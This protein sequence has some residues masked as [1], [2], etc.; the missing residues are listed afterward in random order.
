[1]MEEVSPGL[2]TMS[3]MEAWWGSGRTAL[4]KPV[5]VMVQAMGSRSGVSAYDVLQENMA[6][7]DMTGSVFYSAGR[8]TRDSVAYRASVMGGTYYPEHAAVIAKQYAKR[9]ARDVLNKGYRR[10]QL[11]RE[12][13]GA[14]ETETMGPGGLDDSDWLVIFNQVLANP[15]SQPAQDLI[16]WLRAEAAPLKSALLDDYLDAVLT[17]QLSDGTLSEGDIAARNGVTP[18]RLSQLKTKFFA[19]MSDVLG[20][21]DPTRIPAI[22]NLMD[23]GT[24]YYNLSRGR[25]RGRV[26]R[27]SNTLRQRVLRLAAARP[28]LRPYLLPLL[29][30][31]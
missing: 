27:D 9:Q 30:R 29:K 3:G 25:V 11:E 15:D 20:S 8:M 16:N 31:S 28:A 21:G 23:D 19:R 26:A 18:A 24:F 10:Q 12:E 5:W 13:S 4:Y 2:A 14:I 6:R 22:K 1:M 17:G 7:T